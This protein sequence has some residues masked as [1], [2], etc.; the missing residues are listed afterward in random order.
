MVNIYVGNTTY[1]FLSK[2][3]KMYKYYLKILI[4]YTDNFRLSI[5]ANGFT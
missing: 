3:A 4:E 1:I 2:T 5:L